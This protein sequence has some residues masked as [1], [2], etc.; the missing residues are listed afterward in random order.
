[1][2]DCNAGAGVVQGGDKM[3]L[4]TLTS[5]GRQHSLS[6]LYVR[7]R[8]VPPPDSPD[9]RIHTPE[10][11]ILEG[12]KIPALGSGMKAGKGLLGLAMHSPCTGWLAKGT[13]NS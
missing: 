8:A 3:Q 2:P 9:H 10:R 7:T 11:S 12:S 1:M 6:L 5:L 4:F 13:G